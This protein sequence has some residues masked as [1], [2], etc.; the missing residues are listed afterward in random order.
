MSEPPKKRAKT[1]EYFCESECHNRHR[2]YAY[3]SSRTNIPMELTESETRAL[4]QQSCTYCGWEPRTESHRGER[5]QLCG[6]DRVNP[7]GGYTRD[8]VVPCC[9]ACNYMKGTM[10]VEDFIERARRIASRTEEILTVIISGST[11][12]TN[13]F[14]ALNRYRMSLNS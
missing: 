10:R 1:S 7:R 13:R 14:S 12:T 6:I 2:S 5:I 11:S 9:S 8:N 4:Y 3:R